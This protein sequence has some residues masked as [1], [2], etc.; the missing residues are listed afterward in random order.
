MKKVLIKKLDGSVEPFDEKKLETSLKRVGASKET[1]ERIVKHTIDELVEG[2]TTS[3]IY[4]NAFALLRKEG[5]APIAARYSLKRAVMLPS[6]V[7][8]QS[9]RAVIE[10]SLSSNDAST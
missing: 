10:A 4:K 1:T 9:H 2:M 7:I 8:F 6:C 5:E 3:E